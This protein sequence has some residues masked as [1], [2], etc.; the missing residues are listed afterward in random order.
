M[1]NQF[2]YQ[3][4]FINLDNLEKK[5]NQFFQITWIIIE[6]LALAMQQGPWGVL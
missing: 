4:T 1:Q 5:S 2:S 6:C 3:K